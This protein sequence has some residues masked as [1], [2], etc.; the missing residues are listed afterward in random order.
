MVDG[1][2]NGGLRTR[3]SISAAPPID[4]GQILSLSKARG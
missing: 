4:S 2:M 3:L 1:T